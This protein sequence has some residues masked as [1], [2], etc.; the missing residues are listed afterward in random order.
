MKYGTF[1]W[2]IDHEVV[3]IIDGLETKI[4]ETEQGEAPFLRVTDH[5]ENRRML[6]CCTAA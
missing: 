3:E 2:K 6:V 4:S 5:R 1:K